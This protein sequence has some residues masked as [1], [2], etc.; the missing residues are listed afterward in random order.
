MSIAKSVRVQ[1]FWTGLNAG[2]ADLSFCVTY[3]NHFWAAHGS[4]RIQRKADIGVKVAASGGLIVP[5][6]M[7]LGCPMLSGLRAG[8]TATS[9]TR[10][11]LAAG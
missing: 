6:S 8:I 3:L 2:I 11:R 7:R 9:R 4:P 10:L 5:I 1:E